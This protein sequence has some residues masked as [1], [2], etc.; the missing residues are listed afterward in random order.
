[1]DTTKIEYTAEDLIS[2]KLQRGDIL[3]AKPKF[4]RKGTDL[5]AFVEMNDGVKFC[6]IQCKGRT[7]INKNSEIKIPCDYVTPGFIVFLYVEAGN[8]NETN[9]F[10]FFS[11]E[12]KNWKTRGNNYCLSIN[13]EKFLS[14]FESYRFNDSKIE[15]I[16]IVIRNAEVTKEFHELVYG[17]LKVSMPSP[18][19][20]GI[21]HVD[22]K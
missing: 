11:S 2:H 20:N 9:L 10:C 8:S 17:N 18:T 6:R 14:E 16:K 5:L 22:N 19:F 7:V 12:I 1:M 21:S 3:V 4:D 15:L 13:R